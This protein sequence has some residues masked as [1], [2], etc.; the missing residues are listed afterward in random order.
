MSE[1]TV[2]KEPMIEQQARILRQ[3]LDQIERRILYLKHAPGLCKAGNP[4]EVQA[5]IMLA[6]RAAEDAR[7]RLGKVIQHLGDGVSVYDKAA[8]AQA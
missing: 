1:A 3:D 4:G 7:M 5:N 2:T 8:E 6:Y